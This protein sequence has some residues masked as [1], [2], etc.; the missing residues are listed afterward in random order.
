MDDVDLV[1]TRHRLNVDD[2]YRMAE[3]GEP[4]SQ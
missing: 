2:Y 4:A 1:L 3:A